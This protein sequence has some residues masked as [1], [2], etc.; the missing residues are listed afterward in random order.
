MSHP[1]PAA[2]LFK[3][4]RKVAN[5]RIA[6]GANKYKTTL[7]KFEGNL[8]DFVKRFNHNHN[9]RN[10]GGGVS[11]FGFEQAFRAGY[12][13]VKVAF[14]RELSMSAYYRIPKKKP[15]LRHYEQ[16][17]LGDDL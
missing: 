4:C 1:P 10:L 6:A 16:T 3:N 9:E 5:V 17:D 2:D 8:V 13:Q 14:N 11:W 15:M 12:D 7:F